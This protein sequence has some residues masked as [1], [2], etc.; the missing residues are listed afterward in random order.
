M[1]RVRKF[2]VS[3]SLMSDDDVVCTEWQECFA[4][5]DVDIGCWLSKILLMS[6]SCQFYFCS[7]LCVKSIYSIVA[8]LWWP[9]HTTPESGWFCTEMCSPNAWLHNAFRAS[10]SNVWQCVHVPI[11]CVL[12]K[13]I[14]RKEVAA[15]L[16]MGVTEESQKAW[17][18]PIILVV[19]MPAPCPMLLVDY[20]VYTVQGEKKVFSTL[21]TVICTNLSL[22]LVRAPLCCASWTMLHPHAA[23]AAVNDVII[24]NDTWVEQMQRAYT[25]LQSLRS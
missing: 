13:Q 15:M 9:S 24:H 22:L 5:F 25:V 6:I 10:F 23:H 8:P 3:Q 12:N 18:S 21:Y 1:F 11:D 16:E 4:C 19:K 2:C 7:T 17:C 14:I 20:L